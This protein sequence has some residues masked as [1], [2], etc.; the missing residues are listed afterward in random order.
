MRTARIR[1]LKDIKTVRAIRTFRGVKC[2]ACNG[3]GIEDTRLSCCIY[4]G[5]GIV[6]AI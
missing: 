4:G 5:S 3:T 1:G 2:P 6:R